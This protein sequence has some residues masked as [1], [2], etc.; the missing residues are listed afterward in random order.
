MTNWEGILEES[1]S[2]LSEGT[3]NLAGWNEKRHG[4]QNSWPL[5]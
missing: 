5:D 2:D 3:N 1:K 4:K